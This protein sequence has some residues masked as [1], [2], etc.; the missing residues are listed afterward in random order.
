MSKL[1][2]NYIIFNATEI[3]TIDF[4][5]VQETSISTLKYN[6]DETQTIVKY[7]GDMPSS[8]QAL[9]T[10]SGPYTHTEIKNILTGPAWTDPN[11]GL[12]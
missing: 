12:D 2:N 10:K 11:A 6:L 5:Q 1:D 9:T 7:I 3:G 4:D 8:V